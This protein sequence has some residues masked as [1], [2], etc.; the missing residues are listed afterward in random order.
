MRH[1]T[2]EETEHQEGGGTPVT[3]VKSAPLRLDFPSYQ[4]TAS[5]ESIS[6][7]HWGVKIL[8]LSTP[9]SSSTSAA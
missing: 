7:Q 4:V 9:G 3:V 5:Q 8:L 2:A 6:Q 1:P